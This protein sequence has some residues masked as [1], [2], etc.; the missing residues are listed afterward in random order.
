M[1]RMF[2]RAAKHKKNVL[3]L[4]LLSLAFL[5]PSKFKFDLSPSLQ[6]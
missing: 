2:Q 5:Q 3:N 4:E 6:I 1:F